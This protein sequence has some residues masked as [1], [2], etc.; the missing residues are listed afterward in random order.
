ML[1]LGNKTSVFASSQKHFC[2]PNTNLFPKHVFPCLATMKTMLNSS[3]CFWSKRT[4]VAD[5]EVEA[6]EPGKQVI[7]KRTERRKGFGR[8]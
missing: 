7:E 8:E 2:S 1:L 5:G 6:E 4:T 3:Q